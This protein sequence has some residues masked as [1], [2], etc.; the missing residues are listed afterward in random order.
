VYQCHAF[1]DSLPQGKAAGELILSSEG[2]SYN[3]GTLSGD[4]PFAQLNFTLGG[5][6]N[7]L[8]F[9]THPAMADLT[10]YTSDLRILKNALLLA[11][12]EC[13]A[14]I[15][16]AQQARR[17][18]WAIFA[19]MVVALLAI[20][21]LLMWNL[22]HL[23]DFAARK[24]PVAWETKMGESIAAQYRITHNIMNKEKADASLNA[25]VEPLMSA[26]PNTLYHY[27]FT[28]V[29][30]GDLN[31]F[32]LPGGFVT[33]NSGLIL[34]AESADEFLGVLAHEVSHVEAR[35]GIRSIMG[36][37]GIY[38]VASVFLGDITGI[39]ASISSAAPLLMSQ[40][41]SRRFETDA[42]EQAAILMQKANIDPTGLPRFF[43]KMIAEEKAML[44]KIDNKEAKTAIKTAL[45]FLSTHPASEQRMAHLREL[46]ANQKGGYKNLH[47]EF[48]NLQ[49]AVKKFVENA[50]SDAVSAVPAAAEKIH[51]SAISSTSKKET[52][53]A[54]S[55]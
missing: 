19:V 46:T 53:H 14:Q 48:E 30:D 40:Q 23:S 9:I 49:N 13:A 12:P 33:V 5:A 2:L 36:N 47:H 43:E 44:D 37:L 25:L 31:A 39:L 17:K 4:L 28:I 52:A 29:N 41:Y 54:S 51:S 10:L 3:L 32:A 11:H 42:D 7:R 6:S 27:Q 24:I 38:T 18:H 16:I 35:H 26:L 55:H 22:S 50:E 45:T 1:H 21:L 20:P 34:K 15:N 8:V